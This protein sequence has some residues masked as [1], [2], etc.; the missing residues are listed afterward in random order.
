[1]ECHR[2]EIKYQCVNIHKSQP[3][4]KSVRTTD[5]LGDRIRVKCSK[6][7]SKRS[8]AI[9]LLEISGEMSTVPQQQ[10]GLEVLCSYQELVQLKH[11]TCSQFQFVCLPCMMLFG[12]HQLRIGVGITQLHR[13]SESSVHLYAQTYK[14]TIITCSYFLFKFRVCGYFSM[15]LLYVSDYTRKARGFAAWGPYPATQYCS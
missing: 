15:L 1:M 13:K 2:E 10:L 12:S 7:R 4:T 8:K 9:A 11:V 14:Y 3:R 6:Y 5:I